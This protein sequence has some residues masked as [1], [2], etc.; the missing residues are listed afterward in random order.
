M[1]FTRTGNTVRSQQL[2]EGDLQAD[3]MFEHE[4]SFDGL[5]PA[6][7]QGEKETGGWLESDDIDDFD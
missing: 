2:G 7:R 5:S 3:E 1:E 4:P 6:S